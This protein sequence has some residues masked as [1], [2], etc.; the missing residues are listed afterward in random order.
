MAL[1]QLRLRYER[2]P[3]IPDA[4]D[5]TYDQQEV[6]R[7]VWVYDT[8]LE[9]TTYDNSQAF[10]I[11][12][13]FENA[14]PDEEL[15]AGVFATRCLG[16]TL[17]SY[18]YDPSVLD[19][20]LVAQGV[21]Y[22]DEADSPACPYVPPV[23]PDPEP[24]PEPEPDPVPG[25][26]GDPDATNYVVGGTDNSVCLYAP[27]WRALWPQLKVRLANFEGN[28]KAFLSA[29]VWAGFPTG[30]PYAAAKTMAKVADMRATVSP[31]TGQAEFD[32][33][34]YLQPLLPRLDANSPTALTSDLLLGYELRS[35][36]AVWERGYAVNAA[37]GDAQLF[38][39]K[40]LTPFASLPGWHGYDYQVAELGTDAT[41]KFGVIESYPAPVSHYLSCPQYPVPVMWLDRSGGYGYWVFGGKHDPGLLAPEGQGFIEAQTREQRLSSRPGARRTLL[42]RSGYFGG[43]ALIDG[44]LTL[45]ECIQAWAQLDGPDSPWVPVLVEAGES[46]NYRIGQRRFEFNTKVTEAAPRHVQGQ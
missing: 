5:P 26:C 1:H 13:N 34:P 39:G 12:R 38:T 17:R 6:R 7:L 2:G 44:L 4:N 3:V 41:G 40:Q 8:A 9:R 30:H 23:D 35:R 15:A 25:Q 21:S 46:T 45:R 24:D 20:N 14:P 16:T 27:R 42:L 33:G 19:G 32:L 11:L 31:V 18:S 29:E 22:S 43:Q 10:Y 36:G 28:P 37:V